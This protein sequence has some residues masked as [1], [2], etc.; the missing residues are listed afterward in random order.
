MAGAR[1]HNTSS[2]AG[3]DF[4]AALAHWHGR[5][6]R[7]HLPWQHAAP[8]H[9]W[10]SEIMLQQTQVVKVLEYFQRFI[11]RLP[12][13]HAL[14]TADEA[15]VLALW[16]GLG[17]YNRARNLQRA[18]QQCMQHHGGDLPADFDALMALPGIGRST[19]GAI[20]SLAFNR[21]WPILDGNVKRV[22]AR[23]FKVRGDLNKAAQQKRLWSLAEKHLN[24]SDPRTHNQAL[25]DLGAMCCTRHSPRCTQ[26]PLFG[27]CRAHAEGLTEV[28]PQARRKINKQTLQMHT[29][30]LRRGERIALVR[31]DADS[32][33]PRLWFTP[34][35]AED[36]AKDLG[37]R[38]SAV[39]THE[40]THRRIEMTV[41]T[42]RAE[43][44]PQA[45]LDELHWID[46]SELNQH[47]HPRALTKILEHHE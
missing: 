39:I 44:L 13:I 36:E 46:R 35:L 4:A 19:A 2:D 28:I 9:V 22:L 29:V 14:A 15:E 41:Y 7:H 12:D 18:A 5:H 38:L 31:R 43:Q 47:P 16:S 6:G 34:L 24:L 27:Q 33:W 42:L 45:S 8:Y 23:C 26:C 17:Y 10:L 11:E 32:I 21:P 3:T 25:M 30:L 20:L 40:L 37:A 1:D